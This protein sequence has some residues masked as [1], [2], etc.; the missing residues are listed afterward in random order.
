MVEAIM[1]GLPYLAPRESV[2]QALHEYKGNIS[3]ALSSLMPSSSQNSSRTSSIERDPLS[4]DDDDQ[5]PKKKAD[6]RPSRPHPLQLGNSNKDFTN[7]ATDP[8][9][10]SPDP[11]Q[12]SAALSK[13]SKEK[14]VDPDETEEEDWQNEGSSGKDLETT[15]VNTSASDSSVATGGNTGKIIR[16]KLS[17]PKKPAEKKSASSREPSNTSEYDAD[18]EKPQRSRVIAKPRRRLIT[19]AERDRLE[20]AKRVVRRASLSPTS[21]NPKYSTHIAPVLDDGI[22]IL[23][24]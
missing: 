22:K 24:I 2:I 10:V 20:K 6:R 5:K 16:I 13:L 23:S 4:D 18:G 12:L 21:A 15:S 3:N 9:S 14:R 17:Q 11:S 1:T 8:S 19:G 7:S